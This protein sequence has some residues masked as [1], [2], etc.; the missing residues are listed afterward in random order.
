MAKIWKVDYPI[1]WITNE[2]QTNFTAYTNGY[3]LEVDCLSRNSWIWKVEFNGEKIETPF[4]DRSNSKR[5]AM[6]LCEG[7][8]FGHMNGL[9]QEKCTIIQTIQ[10]HYDGK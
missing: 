6:G 4:N 9:Q 8:M 5:H 1:P 10:K 2:K 7:I 3:Y